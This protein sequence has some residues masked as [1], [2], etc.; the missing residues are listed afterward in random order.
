MSD[1][2]ERWRRWLAYKL[3]PE[4]N[5]Y[6]VALARQHALQELDFAAERSPDHARRERIER[7]RAELADAVPVRA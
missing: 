4:T 3:L 6:R 1:R 5:E 2:L 7:A